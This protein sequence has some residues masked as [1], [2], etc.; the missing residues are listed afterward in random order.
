MPEQSF[1]HV[2]EGSIYAIQKGLGRNPCA[3]KAY[4]VSLLDLG[5]DYMLPVLNPVL[6]DILLNVKVQESKNYCKYKCGLSSLASFVTSVAT[7]QG[8]KSGL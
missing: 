6:Y 3:L 2:N 4:T 5:I 7:Y 8:T 1:E